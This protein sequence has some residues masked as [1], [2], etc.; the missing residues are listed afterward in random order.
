MSKSQLQ[1]VTLSDAPDVQDEHEA[2]ASGV[3]RRQHFERKK[4]RQSW[5]AVYEDNS[6]RVRSY[7]RRLVGHEGPTSAD[8]L[9]HEVFLIAFANWKSFRGA[10]AVSSWL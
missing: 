9:T 2:P 4:T 3:T 10:S 6:T 7:L 1:S 8:D 5:A